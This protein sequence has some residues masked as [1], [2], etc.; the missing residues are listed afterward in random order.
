[1]YVYPG[2]A[3]SLRAVNVTHPA[4]AYQQGWMDLYRSLDLTVDGKVV[5]A[6]SSVYINN[7]SGWKN[8]LHVI[9]ASDPNQLVELGVFPLSNDE[10]LRQLS[11]QNGYVYQAHRSKLDIVDARQPATMTLAAEIPYG[12]EDAVVAGRYLYLPANGLLIYDVS[13]PAQP[14]LAGWCVCGGG[15]YITLWDHYAYLMGGPV[16]HV[17]DVSDPSHPT[18]TGSL[19]L[20][21]TSSGVEDMAA[22]GGYVFLASG[23]DGLL[24]IDA[25]DPAHPVQVASYDPPFFMT[26]VAV[27]RGM[28]YTANWPGGVYVS[29]F[30]PLFNELFLP[31]VMR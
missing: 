26:A 8:R 31:A 18:E 23:S 22:E 1:M 29:R 6:A 15:S 30:N 21:F 16:L 20:T 11:A 5:Y 25:R 28:V 2:G 19:T 3:S 24:V 17:V 9:D 14:S 27:Q 13:D 10:A 7:T 12:V 4:Q